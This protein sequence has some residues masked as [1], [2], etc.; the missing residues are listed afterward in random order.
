MVVGAPAGALQAR[1]KPYL[2]SPMIFVN[3]QP[4]SPLTF[5]GWA[6]SGG[7]ATEVQLTTQWQEFSITVTSPEDTNGQSGIH[8]RMG[9]E[10]PGTVWVDNIR[11]YPGE[12]TDNP[13]VNWAR[14]GDF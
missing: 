3:D 6:T 9:G 12:K 14:Q 1:V 7:G 8:F 10:G 11:V 4:I 5:F 13:S 2:G